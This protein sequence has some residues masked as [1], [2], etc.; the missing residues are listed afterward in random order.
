M[1]LGGGGLAGLCWG[2]TERVRWLVVVGGG[3]GGRNAK[4]T[5]EEDGWPKRG[6]RG[7]GKK[8]QVCMNVTESQRARG[9]E[10]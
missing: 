4:R 5:G 7:E 8:L 6:E 9:G 1:L 10:T 2:W 3:G